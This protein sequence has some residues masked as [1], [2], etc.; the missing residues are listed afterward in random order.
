MSSS[1]SIETTASTIDQAISQALAQLG[2]D[3]EDVTIE[4][5]ATPRSGVLGLGAR[6]ADGRGGA[7]RD[8]RPG[9]EGGRGGNDARAQSNGAPGGPQRDNRRDSGR[10]APRGNPQQGR[11]NAPA[12]EEPNGNVEAPRENGQ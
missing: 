7:R 10:N 4:V 11:D 1:D 3:Q 8:N 9:R 6:Q 12:Q 5:L 2:A